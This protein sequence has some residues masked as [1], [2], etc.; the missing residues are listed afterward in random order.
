MNGDVLFH[1]NL[2]VQLRSIGDLARDYM[3]EEFSIIFA[4]ATSMRYNRS[5]F[6][7]EWSVKLEQNWSRKHPF[8]IRGNYSCDYYG[9][10]TNY[11]S[12][13]HFLVDFGGGI[14]A[15]VW[16][17]LF[18]RPELRIC[19]SPTNTEFSSDAVFRYCASIGYTFGGSH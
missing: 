11:L 7:H 4:P 9:N 1:G 3:R 2:G 12:S 14:R 13:N 10:C 8:Y 5:G 6:A 16:H 15:Y 18:V 17:S 19:I